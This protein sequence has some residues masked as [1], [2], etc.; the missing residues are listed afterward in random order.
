[1][2]AEIMAS[3]D[4]KL[5]FLDAKLEVKM[6]QLMAMIQASTVGSTPK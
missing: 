1:M 3:V 6:D 2:R 4:K 5:D